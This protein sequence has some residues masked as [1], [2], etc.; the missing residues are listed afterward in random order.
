MLPVLLVLVV[1]SVISQSH[2]HTHTSHS[3][4]HSHSQTSHSLQWSAHSTVQGRGAV[5]ENS[6]LHCTYN[7][8]VVMSGGPHPLGSYITATGPSLW[9][10][11]CGVI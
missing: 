7:V 2:T 10:C 8:Y 4:T 9:V 6:K 1:I 5:S 3:H 11:V